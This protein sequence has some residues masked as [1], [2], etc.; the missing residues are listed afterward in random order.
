MKRRIALLFA[1][2][3][4]PI[5]A[6][7]PPRNWGRCPAVVTLET[8]ERVFALGDIHGDYDRLV[9]LLAAGKLIDGIPSSP[10]GVRWSGGR[11]VLVVSGDMIDKGTRSL[12]VI[13]LLRALTTSANAQGGRVI[14]NA[15]NH[16]AEFLADPNGKKAAEFRK[17]LEA[18]HLDPRTVADGLDERG[19]GKFLLCLPF[20]SRVNYWFF[21]HAGN[22]NGRTLGQLTRDLQQG[23]DKDGYKAP[24]LLGERGLLETRMKPV[25]WERPGDEPIDSFARMLEYADALGARHIVFGHQPGTYTFN[26]GTVRTKGT[27]FQHLNGLVFLIDTGMSSAVDHSHGALLRIERNGSVYDEAFAIF[28]DGTERRLFP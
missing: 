4:L 5:F 16:E 8:N 20:A 9:T 24:V 17:E 11:A 27:L 14:L 13:A 6:A 3:A 7:T 12:D 21:S 10:S 25:W 2:L 19:V 23:V 22:T 18:A 28:P 1:L 26:D 15:G